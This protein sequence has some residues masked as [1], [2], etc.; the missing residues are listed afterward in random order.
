MRLLASCPTPNLENQDVALS[1]PLDLSGMGDPTCSY[2]T[3]GIVLQVTEL[4]KPHHHDKVE[5]TF[6][7]IIMII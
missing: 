6:R 1:L 2:T 7:G 5:T 4:C 3:A